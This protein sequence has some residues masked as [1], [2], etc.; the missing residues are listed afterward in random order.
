MVRFAVCDDKRAELDM[1]ADKIHKYYEGECEIV[2]YEDGERLLTDVRS[3]SFDALF[4]DVTMPRMNGM[5]LAEKIRKDDQYVKIIFV[6]NREDLAHMGYLYGAFRYVRKSSLEQE[7]RETLE[8][9]KKQFDAA[10]E[11]IRLKTPTGEIT[12]AVTSIQYFE[13]KGHSV[14][15]VSGREERVCGTMRDYED[16][17]RQRGFIRIHKGYLVNFR[18]IY[19]VQK[20][21]V[22]LTSGKE[23]PMSRNRADE[24]RK[25]LL[26]FSESIGYSS[27]PCRRT[28]IDKPDL[29]HY[30]NG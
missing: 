4:L 18:Y 17:L 20:K 25:M 9:L 5:E 14:T 3:Q 28:D 1:I 23:L 12:R 8:S 11:Y 15:M 22:K 7:L 24:T 30:V 21:D 19:S 10:S 29:I 16:R 26:E 2:S 27:T 13:V 6:T